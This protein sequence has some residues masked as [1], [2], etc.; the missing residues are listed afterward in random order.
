MTE[1][2]LD[3]LDEAPDEEV[4]RTEERVVDLA[5]AAQTIAELDAEI[6]TLKRVEKLAE[7]V[8]RSG[9]DR[10]WEELSSLLQ[11]NP[12]MSDAEGNRRKLVI[13]S[14]HRDTLNYLADRIRT[15]VGKPDAVVTIHGGMHRDERR[16]T[17]ERFTQDKEVQI[18]V[19]TDAAGE[20]IN[21]QR[22]HLM[23]NYDLPWN[24]NRIEQRFGRIHRI[25]QTEICHLWNMVAAETRE[26]EVFKTLF[27]KLEEQAREPWWQ[28]L[29]YPR[30]DL[31]ERPPARLANRGDTIRRKARGQGPATTDPRPSP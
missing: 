29:R 24:P 21:L 4:E 6:S 27:L 13:F 19:A 18:L 28:C 7:A 3:D 11:N 26:G 31:S 17:M 2:D 9:T 12:H 25:G 15:L 16:N 20:G 14:E 22:A 30:Q 10:K 1:E 5:T 8:R 23:V